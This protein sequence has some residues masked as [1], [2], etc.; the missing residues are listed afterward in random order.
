MPVTI[1][2]SPE[3]QVGRTQRTYEISPSL[4]FLA[5]IMT[6]PLRSSARPSSGGR[7]SSRMPP[8]RMPGGRA[9]GAESETKAPRARKER[10]ARADDAAVEPPRAPGV[11]LRRDGL[12][13]RVA[14]R[15][16]GKHTARRHGCAIAVA[17]RHHD[18]HRRA[19]DESGRSVTRSQPRDRRLPSQSARQRRANHG[20][21]GAFVRAL[22]L[23]SSKVAPEPSVAT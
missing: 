16:L 2:S 1:Q 18:A 8:Q 6:A 20:I 13:L 19:C 21:A 3:A 11:R 15:E 22:G 17:A 12:A 7:V 14:E 23:R 5:Q 4:F 10:S 9:A